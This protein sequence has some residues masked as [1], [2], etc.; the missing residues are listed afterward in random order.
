MSEAAVYDILDR[1]KQLEQ[2]DRVLLDD[3]LAV[4]EEREWLREA[5]RARAAG[6]EKGIDQESI[7]RAVRSI[8]HG[9]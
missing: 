1:I 9:G 4:E 3:L 6:R 8:R 2:E 5:S 7:D